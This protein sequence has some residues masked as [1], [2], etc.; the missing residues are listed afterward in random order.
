M[1]DKTVRVTAILPRIIRQRLKVMADAQ[2]MKLERFIA[3]QL[4]EIAQRKKR[5][6]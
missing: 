1:H 6:A 5:A 3:Q 4:E 2:G